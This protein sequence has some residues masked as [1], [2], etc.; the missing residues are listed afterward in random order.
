MEA[1]LSPGFQR[2]DLDGDG[3]IRLRLDMPGRLANLAG[4]PLSHGNPNAPSHSNM[5]AG[6]RRVQ[7]HFDTK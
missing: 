4:P 2:A 5:A 1:L 6:P 7:L 3:C